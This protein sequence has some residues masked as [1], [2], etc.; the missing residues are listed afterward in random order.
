MSRKVFV[1]LLILSIC[2][3][4]KSSAQESEMRDEANE[5]RRRELYA[6]ALE[7]YLILERSEEEISS[8]QRWKDFTGMQA[9]MQRLLRC[10]EIESKLD[11]LLARHPQDAYLHWQ[12]ASYILDLP[13]WGI[14]QGDK[15]LRN[16][17]RGTGRH[18]TV[19][20]RD[21]RKSLFLFEKARLLVEQGQLNDRQK[22]DFYLSYAGALLSDRY[23][24]LYIFNL[25]QSGEVM[26]MLRA[27]PG[28]AWRLLLLT[29][30][31]EI[32]A[33]DEAEAY[34]AISQG[35]P[36][37]ANGEPIYFAMPDSFTAA[38][39]DGER[40][41]WLL[42]Q[43]G[44][45]DAESKE[46]VDF[47]WANFAY[48]LYGEYSLEQYRHIFFDP[49]DPERSAAILNLAQLSDCETIAR[50]ADAPRRFELPADYCFINLFK[51]LQNAENKN[52]RLNVWRCLARIYENRRQFEPALHYLRLLEKE[53]PYDAQPKIFQIIGDLGSF[54][55]TPVQTNTE[56]LSVDFK[57][58]NAKSVTLRLYRLDLA[59]IFNELRT[60]IK[61]GDAE[62]PCHDLACL[63]RWIS[64]Y[65]G[66]KFIQEELRSWQE[67]LEPLPQH[68]DTLRN[69]EISIPG[70]GAYWLVA[71]LPGGHLSHIP[72]L[73]RPYMLLLK[74]LQGEQLWQLLRADDGE[75]VPNT[76][77]ELF[78]WQRQWDRRLRRSKLVSAEL[79]LHSDA[80]GCAYVKKSDLPE[81]FPADMQWLVQ[82][83][84]IHGKDSVFICVSSNS[85][86]HAVDD[87]GLA[88][89]PC[90]LLLSDRPIYKPG[91]ALHYKGWLKKPVY[92]GDSNVFVGK[93][94][95]LWLCNPKGEQIALSRAAQK[96]DNETDQQAE[97]LPDLFFDAN[98]AIS[99]EYQIPEQADLG[100]YN[101]WIAAEKVWGEGACQLSFR[102]EEYRKPDFELIWQLPEKP[103]KLGESFT[104]GLQACYYFGA[105]VS[106]GKARIKV[107]RQPRHIRPLPWRAWDWLYGAGYWLPDQ[108]SD[109]FDMIMPSW[110]GT[111]VQH[112][113][114][115]ELFQS[116]ELELNE[117]GR[118]NIKIDTSIVLQLYGEQNQCF[119]IM[120][121]VEDASKR[122]IRA[123]SNIMVGKKAFTAYSW[124]NRGYYHSG[125]SVEAQ[126]QLR[127]LDNK[128]V[129]GKG[130]LQLYRLTYEQAG[131]IREELLHEW[132]C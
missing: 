78:I 7:K 72:L 57:F 48:A 105:P 119:N 56:K 93:R 14:M 54:M 25:Q 75:P 20:E 101:L 94:A 65:K 28:L 63:G 71:E 66:K 74:P 73:S 98:G 53:S 58:R 112:M 70:P 45:I 26:H 36:V 68:A 79:R 122:S 77:L 100:M 129:S 27:L 108:Q 103:P 59:G 33:W 60:C 17:Q 39:N 51:A 38:A 88:P 118:C 89:A 32:P 80:K 37:N 99:G 67:Q 3:P 82:A 35:A 87:S 50:L 34:A 69:L 47:I 97:S 55:P 123:S 23:K 83:R 19:S 81:G 110:P 126:V 132:E 12:A 115:S 95:A 92:I 31:Q 13:S 15:F 61:E 131:Q 43:A 127:S 30:L 85:R 46:Q 42:Q 90:G 6:E 16:Y 76:E 8:E 116:L 9:C 5:L 41:R 124:A 117:Q 84:P 24:D 52:V 29:D 113:P 102:V 121:E 120:T 114:D 11:A 96:N 22:T 107:F 2:L 64:H 10:F 18:I 125:S 44:K 86:F 1:F 4:G 130:V 21:R 106:F 40:L 62:R 49:E 91:Q 111:Y 109:S 104:V 128:P